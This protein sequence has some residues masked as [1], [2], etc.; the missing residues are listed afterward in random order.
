LRS[1]E[2]KALGAK[3]GSG[4]LVRLFPISSLPDIDHER[5]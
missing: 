2:A 5:H 1:T 3:P 4:K